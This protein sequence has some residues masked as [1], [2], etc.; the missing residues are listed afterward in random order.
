MKPLPAVNPF[1]DDVNPYAAP[2]SA[3][4]QPVQPAPQLSP[5]AGLWQQGSLLV[6]HRDA[7]LPDI[8]VKSNQ[9]AARRL[10]RKLQWHHPAIALSVLIGVPIYI[11]LALVLMKRATIMLPLSQE[12]Y[13]RRTRRLIF[14]WGSGLLCLGLVVLGFVIGVQA[15]DGSYLLLSLIGLIGGI[16]VLIYGQYACSM[17][18]PT[19]MTDQ[20]IWL[21]GVHP[22]FLRRL[23][24]WQWNI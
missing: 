21:K 5:F 12:W 19:R 17:V 20:Y 9:P 13:E 24:V 1:S 23:E 3:W 2:Q 7:P 10:K 16:A 18:R 14:A 22:D 15:D 8:C 6:M 4:S 11:I